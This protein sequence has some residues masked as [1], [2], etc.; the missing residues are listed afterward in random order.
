[1]HQVSGRQ[2]V[3]VSLA[4]L[5][6]LMW[7]VL[8]IALKVALQELDPYTACWIRMSVSSVLVALWM[9]ARGQLATAFPSFSV[10]LVSLCLIAAAGLLG[11]YL[12]YN[13]SLQ[14]LSPESAQ[15][16]IQV[17]PFLML[18]G[19]VW[20]YKEPFSRRQMLGAVLVIIGLL[21]FFNK[22]LLNLLDATSDYS[23]GVAFMMVSSVTWAI[24]ALVQ[25]KLL[26]SLSSMAI[27]LVIYVLGAVLFFPMADPGALLLMSPLPMAMLV[28]CCV[29][30]FV[31]Y[32][33]F[34]E[35]MNHIHASRV[36]AI[37]TIVPI[38][39]FAVMT[40]LVEFWPEHFVAEPLNAL[41]Y[42]GAGL[43]VLGSAFASLT[44]K[45]S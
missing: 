1:M 37:I 2:G 45:S 20:L 18:I 3:G 7:G 35:A 26:K 38:L 42:L 29:N 28:F 22:N 24:Y 14:K 30:T 27:M 39:T 36:S 44:K 6:A 17:A 25:K 16:L 32:G 40:L 13:F 12:F 21:T 41:A 9:G 34:S 4:L 8:P 10:Q 33:A 15:L 31:S 23:L 5:T 19:S 43:V 11:N